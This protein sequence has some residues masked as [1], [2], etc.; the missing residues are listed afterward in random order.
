MRSPLPKPA[1]KTISRDLAIGGAL[2]LAMTAFVAGNRWD[3]IRGAVF[4]NQVSVNSELPADL[5]YTEVEQVYD[6]LRVNYD[7]ELNLDDI[8]DGLK[9]GLARATGDQYTVYL[10]EE[11]ST[12]FLNDL[13]GTFTGIGAELG[14]E[15]DRLIIVAPLK[16][17]PAEAAGLQAQ[18]IITGINGEDAFGLK[19]EEAVTKIRGPK[20]TDVTL[21]IFRGGAEFDVTITRAEIVVPSVESEVKD[22]VGILTISRFAEDTV[23]LAR[24]AALDFKNQNVSGVVLDLRNNS[25]GYL[26]GAVDIAGIW[27]DEKVVV[28]Q[29]RGGQVTNSHKTSNRATLSGVPTVVLINAGSASASE[30]VAGALQD[31]KAATLIGTT[32]YGKGSVQELEHVRSGGT[33]KVTIARWFTPNGN[34]IDETG[35]KPDQ[36]VELTDEDIE[37]KTDAQLNA[38]LDFL[39]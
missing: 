5:D 13:N 35:I 11:E 15:S 25:G 2:L 36:E 31:H 32:S 29:K 6:L 9:E 14:L 28:E 26:N 24:Q 37:S 3:D 10:N 21:T 30:I 7:G 20:D 23:E 22:G 4:N 19:V 39:K 12:Q 33:L 27:L 38:A 8:L 18:D 16:G 1:A 17:F 34:T